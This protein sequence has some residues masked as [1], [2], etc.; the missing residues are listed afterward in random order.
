[1]IWKK[2]TSSQET[3]IKDDP[4]EVHFHPEGG[5]SKT[6]SFTEGDDPAEY[7]R[8]SYITISVIYKSLSYSR[9]WGLEKKVGDD[10][11]L[12]EVCAE[13]LTGN[14][15][16]RD[17]HWGRYS[18]SFLGSRRTH[19]NLELS[20]RKGQEKHISIVPFKAVNDLDLSWDEH[21]ALE[22]RLDEKSFVELRDELRNNPDFSIVIVTRLD[23]MG[24][25]YTTWSP[26]ISEG[27]VLKFLDD[28]RDV[29]NLSALPEEFRSVS[30][31][32]RL[33]FS[34]S[35]GKIDE[36]ERGE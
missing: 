14:G 30:F 36:R 25:L 11:N 8:Q 24:G 1:M 35:I 17:S 20:I 23:G 31:G 7:E 5:F 3:N 33:P 27:R 19:S 28:R 22:V 26:S 18:L 15:V 10:G 16:I 2:K 21:F 29:S 32:D 34:I 12:T 9:T 13:T 6:G 4:L